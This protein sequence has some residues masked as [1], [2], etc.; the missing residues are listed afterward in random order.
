VVKVLGLTSYTQL[1]AMDQAYAI[2]D[3]LREQFVGQSPT[4]A[5]SWL[6]TPE[7]RPFR[8]DP[9]FQAFTTRLGLMKYWQKYGP[10]DDCDLNDGKLTCH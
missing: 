6:W 3:Q 1:G 4:N 10:P 7:M 2:A 5:W 8:Q 9:R